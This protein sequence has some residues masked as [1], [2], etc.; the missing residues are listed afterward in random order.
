MSLINEIRRL[1]RTLGIPQTLAD[2]GVSEADYKACR[3]H[4]VK[5]AVN[6]ACTATNP[7]KIDA[8]AVEQILKGIEVFRK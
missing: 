7:R 3:A 6:D 2:A 4:I 8:P 1:S 5:S